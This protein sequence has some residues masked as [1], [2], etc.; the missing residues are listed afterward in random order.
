MLS[1]RNYAAVPVQMLLPDSS[2]ISQFYWIFMQQIW[3]F[4]TGT[5]WYYPQSMLLQ[6]LPSLSSS[7]T[8]YNWIHRQFLFRKL[9]PTVL[10]VVNSLAHSLN[11]SFTYWLN[12]SFIQ[13]F[14]HSIHQ[15]IKQTLARSLIHSL[16]HSLTIRSISHSINQTLAHTIKQTLDQ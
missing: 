8:L 6:Y 11:H 15:S 16:N 3:S 9:L 5:G 13:L 7:W 2:F 4:L 10:V 12:Q 1:S 14:N